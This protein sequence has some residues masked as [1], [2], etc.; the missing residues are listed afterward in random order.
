[1]NQ[2]NQVLTNLIINSKDAMPGGGNLVFK[3]KNTFIDEQSGKWFP[4]LTPG[5]YAKISISD[6]GVGMT[7]VVKN[8]IFDPFF[9][10]KG[11]G[12]GT[13]LGLA[14]VYGIVKNHGG[15][16]NVYSEPDVG[17]TFT[18]YFPA[19]EK[20]ITKTVKKA[21]KTVKGNA[22]I[23]VIDD[24]EY[25]RDLSKSLLGNMGYKIFVAENGSKG[26][27]IYKEKKME[28]DLV[29]LDIIMPEMPGEEIFKKL[30]SYDPDIRIVLIRGFSKEEKALDMLNG[31]AMGFIQKPFNSGDLSE[32]INKAIKG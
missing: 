18:L 5:H 12:K 25:V 26:L 27:R 7:K 24:E 28:I 6:S 31:G 10:T 13:G 2:I 4:S 1:M 22:T 29:L 16:I 9:T 21:K 15:H 19:S 8:S 20:E 14:T 17:T 32:T 11:E 3:I 23:L 30:V